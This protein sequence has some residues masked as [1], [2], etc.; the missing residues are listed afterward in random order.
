MIR[1]YGCSALFFPFTS[2]VRLYTPDCS[3]CYNV[4]DNIFELWCVKS[5]RF[6][7]ILS[8]L[9]ILV[10][11]FKKVCDQY[12]KIYSNGSIANQILFC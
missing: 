5:K 3:I 6:E 11:L 7:S 1:V 9:T 4:V 8:N 12:G 10:R 2:I